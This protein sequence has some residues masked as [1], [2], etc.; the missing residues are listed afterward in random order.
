MNKFKFVDNSSTF[1]LQ[2]PFCQ[3]VFEQEDE[4]FH[5]LRIVEK[6]TDIIE[7]CSVCQLVYLSS[8]AYRDHLIRRH[9]T[10]K[11]KCP[12]C[13][14]VVKYAC[15][16]RRHVAS[17]SIERPFSCPHCKNSFKRKDH[18]KDHLL[19]CNKLPRTNSW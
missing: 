7:I 1:G 14:V 8:H 15:N 10:A 16:F 2:C 19:K 3:N 9:S 17:H 13:G 4:L 18:L 12:I 11:N 5:H 6:Y